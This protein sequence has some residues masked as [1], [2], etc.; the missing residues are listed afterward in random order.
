MAEPSA[1]EVAMG[2]RWSFDEDLEEAVFWFTD[3]RDSDDVKF[4]LSDCDEAVAKMVLAAL[5]QTG[6]YYPQHEHCEENL[7]DVE[8]PP[9][10]DHEPERDESRD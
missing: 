8:D 1:S 6:D 7:C 10:R 3:H 5:N 9:E 2:R 4:S